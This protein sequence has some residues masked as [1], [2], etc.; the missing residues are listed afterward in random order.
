MLLELMV[1]NYAVV[2][3]LRLRFYPGLNV[4]TGETGSGK[5]I[6]VDALSLLFGGRTSTDMLRSGAER[7]R[8]SGIFETS[9][10]TAALLDEAGFSTEE[11]ELLVE[12]EI[13]LN[14][15]SR[16]FL[17]SRPVTAALL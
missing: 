15:K 5:S 10:R 2:E 3:Q 6:I 4:L 8:V 11:S 16:A 14:G 7:A 12:R 9:D 17:N 1:E 13:L